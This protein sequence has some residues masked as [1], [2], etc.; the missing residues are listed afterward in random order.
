MEL[1]TGQDHHSPHPGGRR[2]AAAGSL[3]LGLTLF[4]WFPSPLPGRALPGRFP[5]T[6]ARA[7]SIRGDWLLAKAPS[8]SLQATPGGVRAR[9]GVTLRPMA[10]CAPIRFTAL[11]L[12]WN[13]VGGGVLRASIRTGRDLLRWGQ[14]LGT[15][16]M[17]DG[18]DRGSPDSVAGRTGTDLVWVG[19]AEC[20]RIELTLPGHSEL[21]DMRAIYINTEGT[22]RGGADPG[23]RGPGA[24][25]LLG[26][27]AAEAMTQRPGITTRAGWG[28]NERYR[29]CGPYYSPRVKMAFVHHTANANAYRPSQSPG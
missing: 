13:Q 10:M 25:R 29:N 9:R 26:V 4:T 16:T 14:A 12:T 18:P 17:E 2:M 8:G 19:A 22:A 27:T 11:A 5:A 23:G 15:Q 21:S 7:V 1:R 20:A 24:G 3:A 6:E 28:A